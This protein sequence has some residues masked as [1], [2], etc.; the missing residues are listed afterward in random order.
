[1]KPTV[2]LPEDVTWRVQLDRAMWVAG[3]RA[4][5]LQ[6]L[7]PVAMQGVWQC[8]DFMADPVGRLMRTAAYVAVTTY[9]SPDE[10]A[11]FGARV[12]R[13]HER[14]SF[15]DP[16]TGRRHRVDETDLLLWVHCAE[17]VSYLEVVTRSG[18][19]LTRDEADRYFAEQ[20]RTAAHVGLDPA[21]VPDS[22]ERMR[23]YLAAVRPRL[24]ASDAAVSTV[25]FLLWPAV[26]GRLRL[27]APARPL[28]LPVGALSYY[29]LPL[30]AR[31]EY[32]VLP[33]PPGTRTAVTVALGA[34]RTGLHALP[35]ALYDR[36]FDEAAARRADAALRRLAEAGYDTGRGLEGLRSPAS[37]P[38]AGVR[39][40]WRADTGDARS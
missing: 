11:E 27:L 33:E 14:L 1:M 30:W 4:L 12:R 25:R 31:R 35:P 39:A 16:D 34:L 40:A 17:V 37:W 7:H 21:D 13:V 5:M 38:P 2:F 19:R 36:L 22:A 24:G 20:T 32:R 29:T 15:T 10:A 9:G 18:L 8:S 3:V 28:W 23:R 6:A 26:P